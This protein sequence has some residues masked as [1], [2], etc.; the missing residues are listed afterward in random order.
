MKTVAIKNT[1][2]LN[3]DL[4]MDASFHLSDGIVTK[5]IIDTQCPY[6]SV[7]LIEECSELFKGNIHKRV[8]VNSPESGIMFYTAS[9][10]FKTDLN[11]NKYLSRKHA[12]YLKELALKSDWIL[13]T[14]SG[15]I[16]KVF[17]TTTDYEGKIGTDDLV[18]IK[19]KENLV[20]RGYLYAF[21]TSKY[22]YGLITQSSYGGVV[23]HI[24]PHHIENIKIPV[25]PNDQQNKIQQLIIEAASLRV[26]AN[27]FLNESVNYLENIIGKSQANLGFQTGVIA[28][29]SVG[30]FNKRFD[31]QYNLLWKTLNKEQKTNLKYVKLGSL[32]RSIFVGG[33]GKRM[34]VENGVPFLSSSEMMLFN[35]KFNCK[36]V[37]KLTPGLSNMTVSKK[38]ILISR[39]G[40]VGNVV[41]VG[42]ELSQT[43]ISEHALRL[44]IDSTKIFPNYIFCFL[45]TSFGLKTMEASSFGS[46]IITLNEELIGNIEVPIISEKDQKVINEKIEL[47]LTKMDQAVSNENQ[48]INIVEKEI[49][50]WQK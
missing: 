5:R 6:P 45:K 28:S 44:V 33:R 20:K 21:L 2:F 16:G 41:L 43:A 17:Y 32:A 35:P 30:K 40:T 48:A 18:R 22:G 4:R 47:Y 36:S 42:D 14:R 10:L 12:P 50:S 15:T 13:I 19:P 38:D 9:D 25:L 27:V 37:S 1:W 34:Y 11:S 46:V 29:T 8:Y 49:E 31:G 26:E 24:E 39:S 7:R 3:S 23:K